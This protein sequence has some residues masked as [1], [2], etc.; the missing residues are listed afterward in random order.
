M[1]AGVASATAAV[2]PP[3]GDQAAISFFGQ[4]ANEYASVPGAKI[5]E[6][7]YFSLRFNGGTSVSYH[8][9][10][11]PPAGYTMA[12]ATVLERLTGGKISAYLATITA[13]KI[14]RLRVLAQGSSVFVSTSSC[15]TRVPASYS[16]LGTGDRY[17]FNDG[18]ASFQPLTPGA[19]G[20]TVVTFAYPWVPGA[21]A[22]ERDVFTGHHPP[23]VTVDITVTGKQTLHV[24]KSISPLR[25]APA[26][27]LPPS[28]APPVPK[29][30]CSQ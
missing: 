22:T 13:P 30:L 6:T 16:P 18:G 1:S 19:G 5:V 8:W 3:K 11:P 20:S 15:W 25:S 23:A 21:P 28:P 26:L 14:P 29:P 7:G 4:E 9:G 12:T 17:L 2:V 10:S 27:P 24:H